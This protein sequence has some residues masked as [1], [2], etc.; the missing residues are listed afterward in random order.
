MKSFF[1][2]TFVFILA[3]ALAG[4]IA[5]YAIRMFTQSADEIVLPELSGKNII[6]VLETLTQMGLNIKLDS[7]QYDDSV[8]RYSVISQSPQPGTTMK[9]GRNVT[10]YLSKGKKENLIP[11]LRLVELSQARLVLEKNEFNIRKICYT[12][13]DTTQKDRVI[14]QYPK[15]F[16]TAFKQ[17][18]CDLLVSLGN[19]IHAQLM[20][21]IQNRPID[22]VSQIMDS[23][24][25]VISQITSRVN[26]KK[27]NGIVL[28]QSP[29][30]GSRVTKDTPISLIV[31]ASKENMSMSP[32]A[33]NQITLLMYPLKSGFLNSHVRVKMNISNRSFNLYDEMKKPGETIYILAPS[34]KKTNIDIFID[35][36][37]VRTI[38]LDPWDKDNITGDIIPWESLPLPFYQPISLN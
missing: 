21:N 10:I 14:A 19:R 38:T 11:D 8:P 18:S 1:K 25:L 23:H 26:S 3:F 32:S 36:K 27:N 20:P 34:D 35:S 17:S 28:N 5:F 16:T 12:Y 2:H 7:T 24:Q 37:L 9:K 15:P 22:T 29:L 6:Y 4:T 31:N 33:L 13:S 30:P